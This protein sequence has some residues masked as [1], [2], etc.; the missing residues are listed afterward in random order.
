MIK[1]NDT[2]IKAEKG[3]KARH[4]KEWSSACEILFS[5]PQWEQSPA[6]QGLFL[7]IFHYFYSNYHYIGPTSHWPGYWGEC[8]EL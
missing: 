7:D 4:A 8:A 2:R 5:S 3:I 6:K 1:T